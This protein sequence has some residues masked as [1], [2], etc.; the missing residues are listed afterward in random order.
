MKAETKLAEP[1]LQVPFHSADVG[2]AEAQ[3]AADVIRSGWLT[4]GAR[5][6]EFER[7]FAE[8]VGAK[9]AIAVNSCT[10]ALH[11]AL[12]AIHLQQGDEV[13]VPTT[14]FT[15]TGEVVT[16]FGAKP[17][18]VDVEPDTLLMSVADAAA[19]ITPKTKAIIPVHYGGQPCDMDEI[20]ALA[21]KHNIHVIEDAAHSLPAS[22]KG[23]PVGCISE[24]TAFSF[25][26]TKTL[27][28]GEGGMITTGN[29]DLAARMRIMRLHGIG[30]DAWKRYSAEGS[31]YYEVLDAGFKYN[32][33]DIAAAIG[34]VQL[35]KCDD[36]NVRRAAVVQRYNDAFASMNELQVPT[37]KPDRQSA[38]HLYPLRFHL[39]RIKIDRKEV[40]C[41][42]KDRGI[43]T[44]VH[45]IPL[46]LHPYYQSAYGYR[47]GDLPAAEREYERYVS[48]PLFPG[49]TY[50]QIDHVIHSVKQIVKANRR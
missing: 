21:A 11:L 8:Y 9:H 50:E 1:Q 49:M 20:L 3:A 18:L 40:I 38:W 39:D 5:T 36:M 12:E 27:S 7:Q 31:W 34:L 22:Y 15:A 4:M 19:R 46:H 32:L 13:L 43:G 23:R 37:T 24:I 47:R 35:G 10:A 28:T 41:Q 16:Y 26:A 14:T 33:T 25:Y 42:L 6:I 17:V 45:F 48:L 30:R 2:E 44:S 29:D